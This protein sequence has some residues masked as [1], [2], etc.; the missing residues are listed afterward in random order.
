[1]AYYR[2]KRQETGLTELVIGAVMMF[3]LIAFSDDIGKWVA[4]HMVFG[5]QPTIEQT[6]NPQ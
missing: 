1:M 4:S 6:T 2:R 5:I 3:G